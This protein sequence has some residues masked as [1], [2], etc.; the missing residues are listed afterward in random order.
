M[1]SK[2]FKFYIYITTHHEKV[3]GSFAKTFNLAGKDITAVARFGVIPWL[4]AFPQGTTG[5]MKVPSQ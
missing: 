1:A 2:L 3:A 5:F 4:A